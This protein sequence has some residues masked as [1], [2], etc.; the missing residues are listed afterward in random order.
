MKII[1]IK[2][3]ELLGNEGDIKDVKSGYARN[4]LIPNGIALAATPSNIKSYQEVKKQKSRKIQKE[5]ESAKKTL[6]DLEKETIVIFVKASD[7]NKI[8]GSVTAQM[9]LDSLEAKGYEGID[10]RKIITGEHIKTIGEHIVEV[11][12]HKDVTAKIN[13]KVEREKPKEVEKSEMKVDEK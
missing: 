1:L 5:I 11:K 12:L 7:E 3:F 10:K 13:V 8:Y 6:K 2:D 4:Y 9:I